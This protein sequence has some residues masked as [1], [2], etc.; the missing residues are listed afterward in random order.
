MKME[1]KEDINK[2]N[3]SLNSEIRLQSNAVRIKESRK[4]IIKM[5]LVIILAF[6]VCWC[7]RYII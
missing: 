3:W 2:R 4:Q 6:S 7:P 1:D 5:L